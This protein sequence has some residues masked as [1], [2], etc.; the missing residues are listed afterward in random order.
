MFVSQEKLQI[1]FWK[2]YSSFLLWEIV[3]FLVTFWGV[4][5]IDGA[6]NTGVYSSFLV[7]YFLPLFL[8]NLLSVWYLVYTL[9]FKRT[10]VWGSIGGSLLVVLLDVISIGVYFFITFAI[11]GFGP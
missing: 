5:K 11:Y 1:H 6:A 9:R 4:L 10:A 3:F 2:I 7:L 8:L